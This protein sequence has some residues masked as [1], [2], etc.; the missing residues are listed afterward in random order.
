MRV[1]HIG[2]LIKNMEKARKA[3][4]ALGYADCPEPLCGVVFDETRGIDISFIEKDGYR[5]ELICPKDQ[6]S[7]F[8]PLLKKYKNCAYHVC[9][10]TD[11]IEAEQAGLRETGWA[12]IDELAPAPAI[13]GKRVC[14]MV[15]PAI[16]II[17]L[18]E[19]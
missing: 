4:F 5:V 9:Y 18:V 16:G 19:A 1:H 12:V 14:F 13:E 17:E 11:D 10:E 7:R 15:N 2:Y 6:D 3:F 8:Y